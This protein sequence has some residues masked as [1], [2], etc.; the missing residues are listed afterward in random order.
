M[1]FSAG[2]DSGSDATLSVNGYVELAAGQ[3]VTLAPFMWMGTTKQ[4][5]L[6]FWVRVN[7]DMY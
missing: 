1:G 4:I 7:A 2:V 5:G 6:S 3:Y